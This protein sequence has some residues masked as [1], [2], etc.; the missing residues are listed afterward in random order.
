VSSGRSAPAARPGRTRLVVDVVPGIHAGQ[1]RISVE[2][3]LDITHAPLIFAAVRAAAG[4]SEVCLD[5][6]AAEFISLSVLVAAFDGARIAERRLDIVHA[7]PATV[8]LIALLETANQP[9]DRRDAW[10]AGSS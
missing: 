8:H 4:S 6:E 10:T 9:A 1:V 7:S 5:L 3:S 2:G